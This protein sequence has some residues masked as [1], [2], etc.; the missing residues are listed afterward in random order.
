MF[1]KTAKYIRLIF[2]VVFHGWFMI[3]VA[4]AM[5]RWMFWWV[6]CFF[7]VCVIVFCRVRVLPGWV[8][9]GKVQ[10]LSG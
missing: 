3:T 10:F 8:A 2:W 7:C 4:N 1:M 6:T 9:W 5:S